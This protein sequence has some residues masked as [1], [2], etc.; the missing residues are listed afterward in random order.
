MLLAFCNRVEKYYPAAAR[1][2]LTLERNRSTSITVSDI[3]KSPIY[4]F[5]MCKFLMNYFKGCFSSTYMTTLFLND[6][7]SYYIFK[8]WLFLSCPTIDN[9]PNFI[10]GNTLSKEKHQ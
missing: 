5:P 7:I 1:Q 4:K 2:E 6:Y 10:T 9:S 3:L 8:F